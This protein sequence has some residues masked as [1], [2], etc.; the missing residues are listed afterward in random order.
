MNQSR[1]I[2]PL[3]LSFLCPAFAVDQFKSLQ[4]ERRHPRERWRRR[5][6]VPMNTKPKESSLPVGQPC[7]TVVRQKAGSSGLPR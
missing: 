7:P 3:I 4:A 2:L 1:L 5:R 6:H